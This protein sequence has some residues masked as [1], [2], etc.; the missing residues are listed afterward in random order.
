MQLDSI[1]MNQT[2]A[3]GQHILEVL[4][5]ASKAQIPHNDNKAKA[6]YIMSTALIRSMQMVSSLV[7]W[8]GANF[9]PQDDRSHLGMYDY[10]NDVSKT[11]GALLIARLSREDKDITTIIA[12][13]GTLGLVLKQTE[14]IHGEGSVEGNIDPAIL[15][16][17]REFDLMSPTEKRSLLA[18]AGLSLQ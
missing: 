2:D 6:L 1:D 13:P 17:I 16:A 5:G 11:F 7:G 18:T 15:A 9:G 4:I 12:S 10:I 3:A 14:M 8:P